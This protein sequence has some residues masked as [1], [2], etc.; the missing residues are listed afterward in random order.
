MKKLTE[1]DEKKI[2]FVLKSISNGLACSFEK[3][4]CLKYL[5]S[6]LR[7]K[8]AVCRKLIEGDFVE[9]N[10]YKMHKSCESRYRGK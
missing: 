1:K 3:N 10:Q 9:K 7:P 4:K 6:V 2:E 8:C 5:D